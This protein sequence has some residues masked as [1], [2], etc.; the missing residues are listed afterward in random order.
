MNQQ[1]T[2]ATSNVVQ[3]DQA[4]TASKEKVALCI[5]S[6][7]E[8]RELITDKVKTIKTFMVPRSVCEKHSDT[9]PLKQVIPYVSFT[10]LSEEGTLIFLAY[11][12]PNG[13]SEERL[14]GDTS[15]GFG[16]HLDEKEDLVFS[17]ET[18]E[19]T[20]PGH[21]YPCYEMTKEEFVRTVYNCA[22]RELSEEL[23]D[24]VFEKLGLTYERINMQVMED[25][26]PD[27]V[28]RV[29]MCISI[30]VDMSKEALIGMKEVMLGLQTEETKREINNLRVFGVHMDSLAKGDFEQ[31][32]NGMQQVLVKDHQFERWSLRILLQRAAMIMNFVY[33][34]ANFADFFKAAQANAEAK[35]AM[36]QK[37]AE[38]IAAEGNLAQSQVLSGQAANDDTPETKAAEPVT[39]SAET[40]TS[41]NEG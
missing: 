24:D 17:V 28:G 8:L 1:E 38:E 33:A 25:P 4:R 37:L 14:H 29:H 2:Q 12:R 21:V 10:A 36:Q 6:Y 11:N 34:N 7:D 40:V 15:I 26:E 27:D 5:R 31:S 32:I 20:Y 23:N 41:A 35:V 13:G 9:E 18:S 39:A 16:G 3:L 22:A 19:E 30:M